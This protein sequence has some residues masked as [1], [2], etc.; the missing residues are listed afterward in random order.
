MPVQSTY[1]ER[2]AQAVPGM[3]ASMVNYNVVTRQVEGADIGFGL[4]VGKGTLDRQV[5]LGQVLANFIGI[6][7]KDTTLVVTQGDKYVATNNIAVQ[8][9]GE[10]WVRPQVT[11]LANDPVWFNTVTGAFAKA[12]GTSLV[13][14]VP[15]AYWVTGGSAGGL[16][17]ISLGIQK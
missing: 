2:I 3:P 12:T 6:S 17:I 10:I 5:K 1:V 9:L 7:V 16:A 15:G 8:T 14:P 4:A 13:G 11:V